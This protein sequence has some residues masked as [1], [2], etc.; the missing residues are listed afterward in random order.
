MNAPK[1]PVE[2]YRFDDVTLDATNRRIWHKG[3]QIPL[4]SKYFDVLL[5]L[6]RQRGRLVEKQRIFDEVWNGIFVTDAA[7]TQ[8]IK[9]I[10]RQLGDD[11]ANPRYIKTVPKH[12]YIFIAEGVQAENLATSPAPSPASP[13]AVRVRPYKFLDSYT[14]Q[15]TG[16][17]FGRE[18]E[19]E[20]IRSRSV[21]HR[22]SSSMAAPE[23]ARPP[24]C[25]R[26]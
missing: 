3:E 14:E 23:S 5:L 12:G 6:V 26:D 2:A 25:A 7:L 24:L 4:N 8:C 18:A 11:A 9:D 17:F 15:D 19:V 16:I 13:R 1:S 21:S 20:V 22:S 10:R